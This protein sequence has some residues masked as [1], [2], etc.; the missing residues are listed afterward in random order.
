MRLLK[1]S[2]YIIIF[3]YFVAIFF[4]I[5]FLT[6]INTFVH[7]DY[8]VYRLARERYDNSLNFYTDSKFPYLP[9]FFLIFYAS[10]VYFI[11]LN[12]I[13]IYISTFIMFKLDCKYYELLPFFMINVIS[14]IGGNI[15]AFIFMIVLI[16]YYYRK[17][18]YIPPILLAFICFK[19]T[20]IYIIPYFLYISKNR[21]K[22]IF[23]YCSSLGL[24]NIY[25]LF[26]FEMIFIFLENGFNPDDVIFVF[27]NLPRPHVIFILFIIIKEK[28]NEHTIII[29]REEITLDTIIN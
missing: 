6:N 12:F 10:E 15:E 5:V 16:S 27:R 21:I 11:I 3:Y 17:S 9:S 29:K 13:C 23:L 28:T 18:E 26:N 22:F 1:S 14:L 8:Q 2:T 24:F 25:F 7:V 4:I 19:P 20:V